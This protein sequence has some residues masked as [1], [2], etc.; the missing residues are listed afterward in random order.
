MSI[1]NISNS[2]DLEEISMIKILPIHNM[3]Y[4][5]NTEFTDILNGLFNDL[6]LV[7][8][9]E[10]YAKY[11]IA[12]VEGSNKIVLIDPINMKRMSNPVLEKAR[13]KINSI[14]LH[15]EKPILAVGMGIYGMMMINYCTGKTLETIKM[16]INT[17]AFNSDGTQMICGTFYPPKITIF[18]VSEVNKSY[19]FEII[20]E[21]YSI[22]EFIEHVEFSPDNKYIIM[23]NN[24]IINIIDAQ[25]LS[26][27]HII[28]L[29][30][31]SIGI[32]FNNILTPDGY[33]MFLCAI[34]YNKIKIYESQEY[35]LTRTVHIPYKTH[36][37]VIMS[38][39]EDM[40]TS[41][42]DSIYINK[43]TA[44]RWSGI[45]DIPNSSFAIN[46]SETEIIYYN[47]QHKTLLM[48][49]ISEFVN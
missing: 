1:D 38:N 44:T 33:K 2:D 43:I 23:S 21:M 22:S 46:E 32:S 13:G 35:T 14:A 28:R 45:L 39:G 19:N 27:Y 24:K 49:D 9:L 37:M 20:K 17:V 47:T 5:K 29:D 42:K 6:N 30:M 8:E 34:D 10:E 11:I 4:E 15:P 26:I 25:N 36:H 41:T 12:V 48:H 3:Y 18:N 16:G 40:I 7:K 31:Y